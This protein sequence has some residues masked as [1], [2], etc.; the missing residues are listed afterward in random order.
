MKKILRK[1]IF[2]LLA[3][4]LLVLLS[5]CQ[6]VIDVDLNSSSPLIVI[7]GKITNYDTCSVKI[8][9]TVNFSDSNVFPEIT[10][11]IVTL[12]D[13]SGNSAI[14]A[15]T[16]PGY[17]QT[18]QLQGISGRT[19]FLN[20]KIDNNTYSANSTMPVL[21]NFDSLDAI[22]TGGFGDG[23][24]LVVPKYKDPLGKGNNYRFLLFKNRLRLDTY[25]LYDDNNADGKVN[26][27]PL[28][29]F[30]NSINFTD[31]VYVIMDGIDAAVYKYFYSLD[32]SASGN[33]SAPANPVTNFTGDAL[34][35]FSAHTIQVRGK[36]IRNN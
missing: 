26:N 3:S 14:L 13:D 16:K 4:A 1:R 15:Q 24:R 11:A 9:K 21:V 18:N 22:P 30:G 19:Y 29:S 33:S 34:G 12:S 5:A 23:D 7:E 20:V 10:N 25:F 36:K 28:I 17:Y 27:R 6:K 31:S 32:Q 8:S 35:Y 2:F